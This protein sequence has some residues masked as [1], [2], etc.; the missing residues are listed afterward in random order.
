MSSSLGTV[1]TTSIITR[2]TS[3]SS[4]TS[5]STTSTT[6]AQLIRIPESF[7]RCN[8]RIDKCIIVTEPA[9]CPCG[10]GG[11][12]TSISSK[13]SYVY[14]LSVISN[15]GLYCNQ[16]QSEGC[17]NWMAVCVN[18]RCEKRKDNGIN[19]SQYYPN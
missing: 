8:P 15:I 3:T 17:K 14:N 11:K 4:T 19:F 2:A 12:L 13:Y 5:I 6:Y 1:R 18:G 9:G 7:K 10:F 16:Y